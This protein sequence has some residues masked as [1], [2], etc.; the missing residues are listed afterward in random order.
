MTVY[1]T[2]EEVFDRAT[3]ASFEG[4]PICDD[5]PPVSIDIDNVAAYA[6]GHIQNVRRGVGDESE[7]LVADLFITDPQLISEIANGRREVSCGYD[8]EYVE[9]ENGR[10]YQRDIRGNH[11]AVVSAGRAGHSVS[12]KDSNERIIEREG[13]RKM[14]NV[15]N[16][17]SMIARLF[18]RAVHDMEPEEVADAI[19]EIAQAAA[20]D[21]CGK[22]QSPYE[23]N[24]VE[25]P[26]QDEEEPTIESLMARIAALEEK[27]AAA[28]PAPVD[29]DPLAALEGEIR[30]DAEIPFANEETQTVPADEMPDIEALGAEEEVVGDEDVVEEEELAATDCDGP[31]APASSRPK[32]PIKGADSRAALAAISAIKPVIA[33]LPKNQ[34]RAAADRAAREIR[35]TL[36]LSAKPQSNGYVAINGNIRNAA[37]K[38][39][40]GDSKP[41]D[42]GAIGQ[43]IMEKFNPHYNKKG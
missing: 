32:N 11:L 22:D 42:T 31:V 28:A 12:I 15:K 20:S 7:M 38:R 30:Q 18:S 41:V 3:I 2:P 26:M 14:S 6:K 27:L 21:G 1:R 23:Q 16:R 39:R 25:V 19:E 9:D 36:G 35:K 33:S 17:N 24:A 5:H 43:H 13:I 8:C 37:Q 29:A 40:A 4:K 34:R 10:I